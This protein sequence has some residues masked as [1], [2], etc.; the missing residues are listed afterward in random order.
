M[1]VSGERMF[2]KKRNE[3]IMGEKKQYKVLTAI[4]HNHRRYEVGATIELVTEEAKALI[5]A[6]VIAGDGTEGTAAVNSLEADLVAAKKQIKDLREDVT[7]TLAANKKLC[8]ENESL[9]KQVEELKA[10]IE[11]VSTTKGKNKK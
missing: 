10:Q 6:K 8:E 9:K 2:L 4:M 1:T 11:T 7:F 5:A 3:E